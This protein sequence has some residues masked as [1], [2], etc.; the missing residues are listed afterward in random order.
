MKKTGIMGGTFNP[1]HYGHLL[2]A[3]EARKYC[4]LDEVLFIPSGN[5]Y[6]KDTTEILDG[7]IRAA[8]TAAAIEDNPYFSLSTI[9]LDREGATYTCDTL[10]E[11]N[12]LHPDTAYYFIMGAD[13]LFTIERWK[14]PEEI[15]EMCTLIAAARG[16]KSEVAIQEKADELKKRFQAETLILPPR[17]IDLSSSE[18]RGKIK[19]EESVRYMV[20]DQ[21]FSYIQKH[22][23]YQ[24]S[25]EN[26]GK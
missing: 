22:H 15:M 26:G 12:A 6:M 2:L 5:S 4:N 3:E 23:L 9:E 18:I 14:N 19:K 1:I 25:G 16:E 24:T 8:M 17:Q 10:R 11:L 20:P 21:V 13:S 7:K